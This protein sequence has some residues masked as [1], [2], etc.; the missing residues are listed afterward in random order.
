MKTILIVFFALDFAP[1]NLSFD[2]YEVCH[3]VQL[4][5]E[6]RYPSKPILLHPAVEVS[7]RMD[8]PYFIPCREELE[9]E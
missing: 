7:N 5:F 6:H 3:M 1:I 4:S 8:L 2:S 9:K